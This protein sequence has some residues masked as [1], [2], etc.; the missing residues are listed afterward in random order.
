MPRHA[1]SSSLARAQ[2]LRSFVSLFERD[3]AIWST[4]AYVSA[5]LTLAED[6]PILRFRAWFEQFYS[7][8]GK[9]KKEGLDW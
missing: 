8:S 9:R 1:C 6:G 2:V 3:S 7:K 4:K 5:P